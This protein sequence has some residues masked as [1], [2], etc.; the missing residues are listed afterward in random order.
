MIDYDFP[1]LDA[2]TD[3]ESWEWLKNDSEIFARAV[4]AEV[5]RGRT[6][7]QIRE[8][9][10]RRTYGLRPERAARLEQAARHLAAQ[11]VAQ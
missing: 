10:T 8:R 4:Q 5:R 1:D 7:E 2:A 3:A 11:K 6:P 9:F